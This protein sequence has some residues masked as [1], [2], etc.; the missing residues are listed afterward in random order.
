[1][2]WWIIGG[3]IG[4][5]FFRKKFNLSFWNAV[6]IGTGLVVGIVYLPV[7]VVGNIM[8]GIEASNSSLSASNEN[9]SIITTIIVLLIIASLFLL[10]LA[11]YQSLNHYSKFS[12][13]INF[14]LAVTISGY[15]NS[16]FIG[17]LLAIESVPIK[18]IVGILYFCF[19]IL[20]SIRNKSLNT[21]LPQSIQ[22]Q[23]I[24]P[25]YSHDNVRFLPP[26]ENKE[27]IDVSVK[28]TTIPVRETRKNWIAFTVIAMI[29]LVFF[30]VNRLTPQL[31]LSSSSTRPTL[32]PTGTKVKTSVPVYYIA[33]P[34]ENALL[35]GNDKD[36][37]NESR[38]TAIEMA[39]ILELPNNY[40]WET[41]SLTDSTNQTIYNHYNN[42][43]KYRGYLTVSN[44]DLGN[45]YY[46]FEFQ[47]RDVHI[48]I[49]YFETEQ[50]MIVF[51][52]EA[53]EKA[54]SSRPLS[55]SLITP[56]A[57]ATFVASKS[58]SNQSFKDSIAIHA[59]NLAVPSGY[60]WEFYDLPAYTRFVDIE[61]HYTNI[62][63]GKGYKKL[64]S[65]QGINDVYLL[66]FRS[67]ENFVIIQFWGDSKSILVFLY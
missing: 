42:T 53:N 33:V 67:K 13:I 55:R 8:A 62:L 50:Q 37:E 64:I 59:R 54:L 52:W 22:P 7:F 41:Y 39:K 24:Q 56:P 44:E 6:L 63:T 48:A 43:L 16:F 17:I 40:R 66:K 45:G 32:I 26:E 57:G 12:S 3:I 35:V 1:M 28:M 31:S 38:S 20:V 51:N 29:I 10:W 58:N 5:I 4:S 60:D 65:N 19:I 49:C 61:N 30:L 11:A 36:T 23:T 25:Q 15:L 9:A 34:P 47:F 14:F 2:I 21:K 27:I 18:I 46:Y